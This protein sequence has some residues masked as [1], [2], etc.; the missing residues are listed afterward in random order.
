MKAAGND[1]CTPLNKLNL[2]VLKVVYAK[3]IG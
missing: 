2:S 3:L 1:N